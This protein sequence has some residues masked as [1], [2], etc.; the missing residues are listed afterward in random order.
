MVEPVYNVNRELTSVHL[1]QI[2]K[3]F[4]EIDKIA[5][6]SSSSREAQV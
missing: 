4:E 3:D 1:Y 2:K 5:I 6:E